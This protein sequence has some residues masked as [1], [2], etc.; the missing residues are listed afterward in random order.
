MKLTSEA[1]QN[2]GGTVIGRTLPTRGLWIDGTEVIDGRDLVGSAEP[3][4]GLPWV[5]AAQATT[6]DVDAAVDAARRALGPWQA[7]TPS[8]R[9]DCLLRLAALIEARANEIGELEARDTGKPLWLARAEIAA[10]ARWY[11]YY[12]GAADKIQGASIE[13]SP[14]RHARTIRRPLGVIGIVAPFNGPFSLTSWKVAPALAAGNTVV[15]KPSPHTPVT[16]LELARL[17]TEAGCPPGV[18][19]VVNGG[20]EVGAALTEHA[21]VAAIAFTGSSEV[22]R[23]IAA[24]AGASLKRVVVEAGGKSPLIVFDDADLDA[25]I[26]AAVAGIWG[27]AGQSCVA[28]SRFVVQHGIHDAFVERM[29]KRLAALRV[30]DPFDPDTQIGPLSTADQLERVRGYAELA[31]SD[32][33]E[34]V[35]GNVPDQLLESGGFYHAPMLVLGANNGMRLAQE[36]IFGPIGLT[37]Q[38]ADEAEAVAIANDTQYGLAAGVYTRDAQRAHR[39]ANLL[40]A[41]SV[42]INTYRAQHWSLPFGGFKQSG[43]GRENGLDV[44]LE[45]TQVQ[46]QVVDYGSPVPDPYTP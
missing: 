4:T 38:F 36:E 41:G 14:T 39:V 22:G 43:L 32:G 17:A 8:Q 25:I 2:A 7:M 34:V 9:G 3:A 29:T 42:W 11:T 21:D 16:A 27:A 23:R 40:D 35:S 30:G 28:P 45:F 24:T 33:L 12:A 44:L 10:T 6:A 15:I 5:A 37:L 31:K 26:P 13:L 20:A 18:V 19:N 46:T 1:S